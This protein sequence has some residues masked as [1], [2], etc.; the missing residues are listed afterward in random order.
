MA[1]YI[2]WRVV[3]ALGPYSS[4]SFRANLFTFHQT[5]QGVK[6]IANR[7][8]ACY[9]LA[10]DK[11]SFALS[12]LYVDAHFT[13]AEKEEATKVIDS[14]QGSFRKLISTNTWLDEPTRVAS[15]SKL[16]HIRKNVAYPAWLTDDAQLD[17]FYFLINKTEVSGML[18]EKNY[19][20][21]LLTF[22]REQ[23]RRSLVYVA[24]PVDV[25]KRWPMPPAIINAAYEPEQ[26]SITIPA[27]ILK[28]PFFNG[29]RPF[30]LNHGSI[31]VVIGHELTHG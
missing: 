5:T 17:E 6:K 22:E 9:N 19:L 3:S 28:G 29:E 25:N 23:L 14:I 12:R 1:N 8:E 30:A 27:G 13:I 10:N 31:G 24:R 4:E 16:N 7:S 11:V 18:T 21:T 26:N 2:G 15:L 20:K